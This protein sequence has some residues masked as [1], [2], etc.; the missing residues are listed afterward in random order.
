M[1]DHLRQIAIFAKTIDHGSF[2][3][4][5]QALGISPSVV[6]HHVS[7]LEERLGTALIYRSTRNLSLTPDGKR[8]LEAARAM[9]EA[10]ET[11][12]LAVSES[13][14]KP[15]GELRVTVPAVLAQSGLV[16]RIAAF[17]LA[18]PNVQLSLDFS[19]V[20]REV[21][22][23]GY[24]IA[25]RMGWLKDS[26]LMSRKLHDVQ[27]RVVASKSY[28]Q[29]RTDP[30][31]PIDLKDWD[32]IALLSV[33]NMK[34]KF[35]KAGERPVSFKPEAHIAV[36]DAH[37]LYR[38]ARAG[39]GVAIVPEFLAEADIAGGDVRDVLPGWTVDPVGVYAVWPANAPKHGLSRLLVDSLSAR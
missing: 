2:R 18:Y 16:D 24:D 39:A 19:D 33:Q 3:G 7:Q 23:E 11:G 32:W 6:S 26:A 21:I 8:L 28:A 1:L 14:N 4:A 20:R 31:S 30:T 13:A 12:L 25:I 17:S 38:L 9:V 35:C 34:T 22:G 15:T 36:N 5:A 27:R 10:A 29:T 37:A